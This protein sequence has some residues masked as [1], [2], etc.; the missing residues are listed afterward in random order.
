MT[1]GNAPSVRI[2]IQGAGPAVVLLHGSPT[3]ADVLAPVAEALAG[4]CRTFLV[5][6]P[7]YGGTER[8]PAGATLLEGIEAIEQALLA[9]GVTEASFVGFSGGSW[10]ALALA[11]RGKIR[12][13]RLALVGAFASLP[14]AQR[15][16]FRALGA[17]LPQTGFTAAQLA[18]LMLSP[19]SLAA[20]P[21]EALARY[22]RVLAETSLDVIGAEL[23]AFANA[24]DVEPD[25]AGLRL[26]LLCRVGALDGSTP[27]PQSQSLAAIIA[28]TKLEIVPD[29]GHDLFFEDP[30]A[31]VASIC[32]FLLA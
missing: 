17:S 22:G 14:E 18:P 24:P 23:V 26:P 9:A 8:L 11:V 27:V 1:Q 2:Q 29:C 19:R 12:P 28:D 13:L 30:E 4:K 7:G 31:T 25:L 3:T 32:G 10:R 21:E 15:A 20:R 5:T 6:T 16:G